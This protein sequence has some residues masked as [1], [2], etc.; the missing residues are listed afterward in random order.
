MAF[1]IFLDA[2]IIL[3][4]TL[5]R[6]IG[7]EYSK[8]II[9]NIVNRKFTAYITPAIVHISGYYLTKARTAETAKEILLSLL[10]DI[11]T[12]DIPHAITLEAL[13][14][15]MLDIEDSLQYYSA[16]HHNVDY[17]IS[18]DKPLLKNHSPNKLPVI[19]PKDFIEQFID[20]S[21]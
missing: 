9:Q 6:E 20:S 18:R 14:S 11:S 10:A 21:N 2:N 1:K 16:I 8:T 3:D 15:N 7:Y 19:H 5:R 17:F 4:F 13:H 12:I